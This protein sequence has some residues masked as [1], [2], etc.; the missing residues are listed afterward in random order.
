MHGADDQPEWCNSMISVMGASS[1]MAMI[2]VNE[3]LGCPAIF[4]MILASALA[5][6]WRIR[7]CA[8][9]R[10][11]ACGSTCLLCEDRTSSP[12]QA[13]DQGRLLRVR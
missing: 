11:R 4:R 1:V 6:D 2:S 3:G 13:G 7:L 9:K 10:V 8:S 5:L 12:A